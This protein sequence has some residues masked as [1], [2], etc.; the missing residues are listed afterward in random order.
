MG[1]FAFAFTTATD[2]DRRV[3]ESLFR[4][5]PAPTAVDGSITG[6]SLIRKDADASAWIVS[7]RGLRDL[8]L[9]TL[10]GAR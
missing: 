7:G 4:D 5:V 1:A 8:E 3:V 2:A 9:Q 6:F 10:G